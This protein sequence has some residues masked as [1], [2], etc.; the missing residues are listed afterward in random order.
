MEQINKTATAILSS[1]SAFNALSSKPLV[2]LVVT[3]GNF[4]TAN[5]PAIRE[6]L[7]QAA[8][9]TAIV[10]VS[11]LEEFVTLGLSDLASLAKNLS[12]S[13]DGKNVLD[14]LAWLA[15]VEVSSNSIIGDAFSSIPIVALASAMG[16]RS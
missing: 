4:E 7:P 14:T 8:V 13:A 5:V 12:S 6:T 2:G 11:F 9:P 3:L 15:G 16:I 1:N 10:G